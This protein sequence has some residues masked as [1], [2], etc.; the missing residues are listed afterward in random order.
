MAPGYPP[1]LHQTPHRLRQWGPYGRTFT[2]PGRS[3]KGPW[4]DDDY[5]Q[6]RY[7]YLTRK[8]HQRS[9]RLL[10]NHDLMMSRGTEAFVKGK[11]EQARSAFVLAADMNKFDPASRIHAAHACFAL[12]RYSQSVRWLREAFGLEPRIRDLPYDLRT[13]YGRPSEFDD[14]LAALKASVQAFPKEIDPLIV[15]GYVYYYIGQRD[16]AHQALR[17]AKDCLAKAA[18][19]DE[20]VTTLLEATAPSRFAVG[21]KDG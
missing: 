17:K 13:D 7:W 14:H 5:R 3:F 1:Y 18:P 15:L 8:T 21:N 19:K 16:Q 2:V 4:I 6:W 12:G 10:K 11:Y 20:L 9:R